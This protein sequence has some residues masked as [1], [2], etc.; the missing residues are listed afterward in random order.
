M[1][2]LCGSC[3]GF[4]YCS[5]VCERVLCCG[6]REEDANVAAANAAAVAN[7]AAAAAALQ[8]DKR[9]REDNK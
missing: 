1:L 6:S 7:A 9:E 3:S 8:V 4:S 2:T 5:S